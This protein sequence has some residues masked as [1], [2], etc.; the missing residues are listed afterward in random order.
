MKKSKLIFLILAVIFFVIVLVIAYD[1]SS[2]TTHPGAKSKNQE[3]L[4]NT[5]V[6]TDSTRQDSIL[7]KK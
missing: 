2:K 4:I 7:F 6:V 5:P 3:Q 1:I